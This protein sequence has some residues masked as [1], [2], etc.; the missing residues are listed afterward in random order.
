MCTSNTLQDAVSLNPTVLK[1]TAQ[2]QVQDAKAA[3]C[4]AESIATASQRE[5]A[6]LSSSLSAQHE[7]QSMWQGRAQGLRQQLDQALQQQQQLQQEVAAAGAAADAKD[8]SIRCASCLQ[9]LHEQSCMYDLT[10][11]VHAVACIRPM[12]LLYS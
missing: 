12:K 4:T 1:R 6:H 7:A 5:Q 8:S 9:L 10:M 11:S 2:W 3:Q